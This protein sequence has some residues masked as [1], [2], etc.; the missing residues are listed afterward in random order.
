[1]SAL[2]LA[3]ARLQVDE[4]FRANVYIDT[5][6]H[7]SIG[8]G[9]NISAGI[10]QGAALALLNAQAGELAQQLA[11]YSWAAGLNDPRMSVLI[12]LA[13]NLGLTGLLHFPLMLAAIGQQNW[14]AAHDQLLASQAAQQLPQRYGV[15]AQILLTGMP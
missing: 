15:L 12:E 11:V 5:T 6:G 14:Q 13:F 7:Q 8:Y 2:D 1:V 9:F 10:S 3:V 4:G